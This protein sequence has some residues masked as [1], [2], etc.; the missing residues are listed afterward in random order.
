MHIEFLVEEDSAEAAL[1]NLLPRILGNVVSFTVHPHQGKPDLLKKLPSRLRA[2][3]HWLPDDWHVVVLMDTD[4]DDCL[5]LKAQLE[6]IAGDARL[7]T[8]SAVP[9]GQQ[10]Q[11]LNRLAIEELEAWFFGDVE[12]LTASYPRVSPTLGQRARYRDPDAITGGTWEAL[13]RL[14]Q[15]LNY[16]PEGLPKITAAREVSGHMDPVRNRSRSFQVFREGLLAIVHQSRQA[17]LAL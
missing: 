15:R 2:Y 9:P 11:V 7:V 1:Q 16:F 8:K 14:L 3:K 4:D 17:A 12:A 13:E 5:E 10:F 6:Q